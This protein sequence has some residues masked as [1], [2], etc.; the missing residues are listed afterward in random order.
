MNINDHN[1]SHLYVWQV[2][3]T[4]SQETGVLIEFFSLARQF[5]SY[6]YVINKIY[7][8]QKESTTGLL[9]SY[10]LQVFSKLKS[11]INN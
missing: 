10:I 2:K 3:H 9:T 7:F 1:K 5:Y 4:N 11:L 6:L 8:C